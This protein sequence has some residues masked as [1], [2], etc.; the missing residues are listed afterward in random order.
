MSISVAYSDV[1]IGGWQN[2]FMDGSNRKLCERFESQSKRLS[3]IELCNI[4]VGG[5]EP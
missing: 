3:M 1:A 4:S 5:F 2:F